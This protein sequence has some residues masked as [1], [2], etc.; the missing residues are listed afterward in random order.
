M[1]A[2]TSSFL[3]VTCQLGAEQA[4]KDEMA[5][6]HPGLR[7]AYSRPGLLTFKDPAGA[8]RD[9]V[10][11]RSVFA[12]AYGAG[13]GQAKSV[14]DAV[15]LVKPL[16]TTGEKLRLHVFPRD[17]ARPGEEPEG[18][19]D[20]RAVRAQIAEALP[21]LEGDVARDGEL[22]LDVVVAEREPWFLGLHRASRAHHAW[23]GG[24]TVVEV[25]EDAPSRAYRKLEEALAWSR[26]PVR[27]GD[28]AVELGSAPG[29]ASL[30]LLRRGLTVV[31]VDPGAMAPVVMAHP[32]FTHLQRTMGHVERAELPRALHW[33]LMDVNMAPQVALSTV[34]RLSGA[35]RQ[36]L[37]GVLLTL[38]LDDWKA[39]R[40]VPK[41][42]HR[43]EAIGFDDVRGTQLAGNRM[44]WFA[45]GL[46]REGL[47]RLG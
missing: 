24:R 23:P 28:V 45:C 35:P 36:A 22:V 37:C 12:R 11:I 39:A 34:Q 21:V 15:A 33:I 16:V 9:D 42:L 46:T 27:E 1:A 47:K 31:G 38:K 32:R 19:G 30:A 25:P 3:W 41:L 18:F 20:V 8:V 26:A 43:I 10:E 29:G 4:V 13:L 6:A 44:E 5:R 14:Q 2:F 40:H 7:L 17:V